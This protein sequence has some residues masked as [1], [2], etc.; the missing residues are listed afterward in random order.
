[1]IKGMGTKKNYQHGLSTHPL[2][3]TWENMRSRCNNPKNTNYKW[4]GAR[5]VIVCKR[6]DNFANFVADVGDKPEGMSLD[7]RNNMGNYDPNN[8]QWTSQVG[9]VRNS[10]LRVTNKTGVKGVW[11]NKK[12]GNYQVFIRA[13]GRRLY[14]GSFYSLDDAIKVRLK[15]EKEMWQ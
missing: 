15:A 1:M 5:G 7:R 12:I 9:Q 13:D 4:Y 2:Y 10:R 14:L 8:I 6:W 3:H 11:F